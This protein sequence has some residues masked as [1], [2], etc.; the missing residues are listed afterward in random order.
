MRARPANPEGP[1]IHSDK[2]ANTRGYTDKGADSAGVAASG[3]QKRL[4]RS[5]G[6]WGLS[7]QT[8]YTW[9]S[10]S[11]GIGRSALRELRRLREE[12]GK[13]K[14]LVADLSLDRHILQELKLSEK[15][16]KAISL[17]FP[18]SG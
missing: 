5:A 3:R 9:K 2:A 13:L 15:S 12:N 16:S 7:E 14:K 11:S 4:G 6:S 8:F 1:T 17:S 18:I 10:K